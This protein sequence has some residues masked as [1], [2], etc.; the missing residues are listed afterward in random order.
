[1]EAWVTPGDDGIVNLTLIGEG[2]NVLFGKALNYRQYRNQSFSIMQLV[3]FS[4]PGVAETARLE[5]AT[6]DLFGRKIS[7]YSVDLILLSL[8]HDDLNPPLS[9]LEPYIIRYPERNQVFKG[10][11]L[12]VTGLARPVNDNPVIIEI[13]DETARV[14]ASTQV[15]IPRPRGTESHTP[16]AVDI[17]YSVSASTP[18]RLTLR[19][20]SSGRIPGTVS[21][22]SM[23]I[24][25]EP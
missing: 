6:N 15:S 23:K 2:G 10:G 7:L 1:M 22:S 25:L 21:L 24:V 11:S 19:Q 16:F 14:I 5:I 9:I 4:I 17:P 18:V 20:E 12:L 8:G 13:I 3:E